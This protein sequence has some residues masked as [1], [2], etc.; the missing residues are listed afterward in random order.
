LSILNQSHLKYELIIIDVGSNDGTIE[1]IKSFKSPKIRWI[2][3]PDKDISE[4]FRI[5]TPVF[6]S[7]LEGLKDQV[8]DAAILCDLTNSYI[9]AEELILI[10]DKEK[11]KIMIDK[12]YKRLKELEQNSIFEKLI[13]ILN[14][15]SN[16]LKCWKN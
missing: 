5:G 12:G 8:G 9:L 1:I 4:A 6:Y 16:K 3:E 7:N 13:F 11:R 15:Y 2:S 14:Q 10:K